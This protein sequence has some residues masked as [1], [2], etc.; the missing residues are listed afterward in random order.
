MPTLT[1]NP[2]ETVR[3]GE[4]MFFLVE[5]SE[6]LPNDLWFR[7]STLKTDTASDALGDYDGFTDRVF[8]LSAGSTRYWVAVQTNEVDDAGDG[9][10]AVGLLVDDV[11]DPSVTIADAGVGVGRNYGT[12]LEEE[13]VTTDSGSTGGTLPSS[14]YDSDGNSGVTFTVSDAVAANE[15]SGQRLRFEVTYTGDYNNYSNPT[16]IYYDIVNTRTGEVMF[17][18]RKGVSTIE[19]ERTT[20][21]NWTPPDDDVY[22]G[23]YTEY[24]FVVTSLENLSG[25]TGTVAVGRVYDDELPA[26]EPDSDPPP[27]VIVD[28]AGTVNEGDTAE[29][30]V[31]VDGSYTDPVTVT[32]ATY[33]LGDANA[34]GADTDYDGIGDASTPDRVLTF[35]P[36]EA[37][38]QTVAVDVLTDEVTDDGE[39]FEL[40][41]E[42]VSS[43]ATFASGE[44]G[45]ATIRDVAPATDPEPAPD[46]SAVAIPDLTVANGN[47]AYP[48]D[49]QKSSAR[50]AVAR[51]LETASDPLSVTNS[52]TF[53]QQQ[54]SQEASDYLWEQLQKNN[55]AV[56]VGSMFTPESVKVDRVFDDVVSNGAFAKT[57]GNLGVAGDAVGV[58]VD[59]NDLAADGFTFGDSAVLAG[60]T[61]NTI[62]AGTVASIATAGLVAAI[63]VT[64]VGWGVVLIG[65]T[66]IT[67]SLVSSTAVDWIDPQT[68]IQSITTR[69]EDFNPFQLIEQTL[70]KVGTEVFG[71]DYNGSSTTTGGGSVVTP[72]VEY[73]AAYREVYDPN[74]HLDNVSISDQTF[75]AGDVIDV[76]FQ[77]VQPDDLF[78]VE[79]DFTIDYFLSTDTVVSDDDIAMGEQTVI[80]DLPAN[81]AASVDLA[82]AVGSGFE[83]DYYV[84]VDVYSETYQEGAVVQI[85]V[86]ILAGTDTTDDSTTSGGTSGGSTTDD[87]SGTDADSDSGSDD[88]TTADPDADTG[89]GDTGTG[90]SNTEEPVEPELVAHTLTLKPGADMGQDATITS[91]TNPSRLRGDHDLGHGDEPTMLGSLALRYPSA[92][93]FDLSDVPAEA[94]ENL[95]SATLRLY[96]ID[97]T[98]GNRNSVEVDVRRLEEDWSEDDYAFG[99]LPTSTAFTQFEVPKGAPGWHDIDLLDYFVA[100]GAGTYENHGFEFTSTDRIVP[101]FATSDHS[102]ADWHPELELDYELPATGDNTDLV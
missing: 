27:T 92:L 35:N 73:D 24:A 75:A 93:K 39:Q 55:D 30:T 43:N 19:G 29:F 63:G 95:T 97:D 13:G 62:A 102:N 4:T 3:E 46:V 54:A 25:P 98:S 8:Q 34:D 100:V 33:K 11:S 51:L 57:L 40:R 42:S 41:V 45:T 14:G 50:E 1:V 23:E 52:H 91:P 94:L 82:F 49:L 80:D 22:T 71:P 99:N 21:I 56:L 68:G 87:T 32:V 88:T 53:G 86:E 18:A 72:L 65:A 5:L 69:P 76:A 84:L 70:E 16:Y 37:T 85:P 10:E 9:H 38:S 31:R 58:F 64:P 2:A 44:R 47:Q 67:V 89:S 59:Y 60:D 7:A 15:G 81:Q 6:P 20:G 90:T 28:D 61:F 79:A 66:G 101:A 83:G 74:W 17:D 77:V 48:S 26:L 96:Q 12:I 36:G 78:N